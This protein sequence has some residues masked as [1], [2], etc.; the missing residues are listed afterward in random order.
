MVNTFFLCILFLLSSL[1][2]DA[3]LDKFEIARD[4]KL[5][6]N[7]QKLWCQRGRERW[8]FE[9]KYE[10]MHG[11]LEG[12]FREMGYLD[13]VR[14]SGMEYEYALVHGATLGRVQ[15]RVGYLEGLLRGGVKVKEIVFL[16][17]MRGL[18]D[19]EKE[20]CGKEW[21]SEMV[22][23]VY[24][25]SG[26]PR[27]VPVVFINAKQKLVGEKL[28]RPTTSDTIIEWLKLNPHPGQC[29]AISNQPFVPYQDA[30]AKNVLP[31]NFVLE[32]VG[33]KAGKWTVAVVLDSVAKTLYEEEKD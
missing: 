5:V 12:V 25:R 31:D 9:A 10:E 3:L 30:V 18:L 7:T 23:W 4:E 29:L 26:L 21:E 8:E 6:E 17:G 27:N 19:G 15:G 16:S 28:I 13:E 22:K 24:E 11:E 20:V 1:L 33:E 14:P 2:P 32:T